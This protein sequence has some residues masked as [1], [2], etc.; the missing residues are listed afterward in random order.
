[1]QTGVLRAVANH[2]SSIKREDIPNT[3]KYR[4]PEIPGKLTQISVNPFPVKGL[5]VISRAWNN[6]IDWYYGGYIM[7]SLS[8][9]KLFFSTHRAHGNTLVR[10]D[11]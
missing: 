9:P 10:I 6:S 7:G 8:K 11:A 2:W 5:T 3:G 4:S 1:M